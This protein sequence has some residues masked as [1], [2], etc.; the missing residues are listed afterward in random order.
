MGG[1]LR[2]TTSRFAKLKAQYPKLAVCAPFQALYIEPERENAP[3][4]LFHEP[5]CPTAMNREN[6][7][8]PLVKRRVS[9]YTPP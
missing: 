9:L 5:G 2:G 7:G 4:I 3:M 8:W 1:C 6:G